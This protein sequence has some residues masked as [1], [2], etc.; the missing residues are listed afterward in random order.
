MET[1]HL[2]AEM[3]RICLPVYEWSSVGSVISTTNRLD[4]SSYP[5]L[6][7]FSTLDKEP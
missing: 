1:E 4:E 5:Y 3:L 2:W 7:I 6:G